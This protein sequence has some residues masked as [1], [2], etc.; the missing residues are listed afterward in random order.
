MLSDSGASESPASIAL[1][2]STICRYIGS[3]IISPPSAICCSV[4]E[5]IPSRKFGSANRPG[6]SSTGFPSR[7][8]R[9]SH[10]ASVP[11]AAKPIANSAATAPPPSSQ[12]R[13]PSTIPPIPRAE[14][15]APT[16]STRRSPV[17]GHV[18]HEPDAGQHDRDDHDLAEEG[19]PPREVRRDEAADERADGG[20]D[21]G[22]GADQGVRLPLRRTLEVPVDER[23]HRRQEKSGAEAADDRPEDDDRDE[24]LREGHRKRA[25][26]VTEQAEH[27]GLL[28]P[29]QVADLAADQDERGRDE[30]LERDRRLDAAR[31]RVE[32]VDDGRDRDVHQRRVDDENEHRHREE[33][34]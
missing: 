21:R 24:A 13:I 23:L 25:D 14:R 9:T 2:S 28:P 22:G 27:V 4:W 34:G 29:D 10:Q 5:E 6:S 18:L 11:T 33:D 19:D 16:T 15:I 17:Y 1:Y 12:T 20:G 3:A 26:R 7:L 8:R 31:R 32:V 30:R